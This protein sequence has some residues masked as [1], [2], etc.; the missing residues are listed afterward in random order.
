MVRSKSSP[1]LRDDAVT[2]I[3]ARA[4]APTVQSAP[5]DIHDPDAE[6]RVL[7]SDERY[8]PGAPL[9]AGGMGEVRLCRDRMIGREVAVKKVL[10]AH[11]QVSESRARFAREARVQ[12]QLEHPAIVPVYDFGVDHEGKPY[13]TMK[14]V[15]GV[16]LESVIDAL[17]RGDEATSRTYTLHKLL[18]AFV[19]VC[20]AIDFAHEHGVLH[21][22]LKPSNVML[23]GYGEVYVLDWGLAKVRSATSDLE[24]DSKQAPLPS[25]DAYGSTPT[26]VGSVLGTPG[27]MAP[28]QIRGAPADERTDVYALGSILF[29][30]LT[31]ERLHGDGSVEVMT[32]RA[33]D[34]I[35]ARPS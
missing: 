17:R 16:T 23:G 35:D 28:E 1:H 7:S 15:R 27:Y 34:G 32:Q 9:G 20:L 19:H 25:V 14:R 13:F 3:Q 26:E 10:P 30:I 8:E 18:G 24:P 6:I 33:L 11:A 4:L 22:D 2:E 5:R 29:E 12:G 21:R 31:H